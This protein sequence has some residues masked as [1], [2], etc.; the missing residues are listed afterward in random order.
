MKRSFR[1]IQKWIQTK[2]KPSGVTK[3]LPF[4]YV[5]E[6]NSTDITILIGKLIISIINADKYGWGSFE[7][8]WDDH[9]SIYFHYAEDYDPYNGTRFGGRPELLIEREAKTYIAYT[10]FNSTVFLENLKK[11]MLGLK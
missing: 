8:F 9:Y 5:K 11:S 6:F 7:F 10:I 1:S 2:V 4:F 3:G